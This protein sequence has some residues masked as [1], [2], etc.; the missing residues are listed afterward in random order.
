MTIAG[1]INVAMLVMAASTFFE[2]GLKDV[3]SLEG[4][5]KTLEPILGG[6]SSALFALALIASGPV[7]LGGRDALRPGRDA[8]VHPAPDPDRGPAARDDAARVR[9]DRDRGRPV[10]H[11]RALAGRALVR[12]PVRADPARLFHGAQDIMGALVN[13]RIT[14]VAASVVAAAIV[15][16]NIFLLGQTFVL[17]AKTGAPGGGGPLSSGDDL[18]EK[19]EHAVTALG[20]RACVPI[21]NR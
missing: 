2:S 11:A 12:D 16:L 14:T 1:L 18:V 7:E 9:R 8:G 10:A 6:A 19:L 3:D 21:Y 13:R 15:A 5:H 20:S 17:A 4:A